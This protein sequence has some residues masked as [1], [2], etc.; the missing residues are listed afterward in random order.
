MKE[1]ETAPARWKNV[2]EAV[3]EGCIKTCE[4]G[5]SVL[6]LAHGPDGGSELAIRTCRAHCEATLRD[7]LQT[8]APDDKLRQ[9]IANAGDPFV[10]TGHFDD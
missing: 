2:V 7:R 4:L 9:A 5:P 3:Q 1:S 6:S 8:A 10:T